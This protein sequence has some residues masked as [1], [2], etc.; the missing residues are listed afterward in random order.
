MMTAEPSP[1]RPSASKVATVGVQTEMSVDPRLEVMLVPVIGEVVPEYVDTESDVQSS[2]PELQESSGEDDELQESSGED[3]GEFCRECGKVHCQCE[4]HD[5]LRKLDIENII[6]D[7][8]DL[9][10]N[11]HE[12][13]RSDDDD[14]ADIDDPVRGTGRHCARSSVGSDYYDDDFDDGDDEGFCERE[15]VDIRL[16]DGEVRARL[17]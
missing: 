8:Q 14:E 1:T 12:E 9:V 11:H 4:D 3:D 10:D 5:E 2:R 17:W 13:H 6:N 7:I 15:D 16:C